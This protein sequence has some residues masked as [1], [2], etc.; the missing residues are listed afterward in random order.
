MAEKV[1]A[2]AKKYGKKCSRVGDLSADFASLDIS[3]PQIISSHAP[4]TTSQRLPLRTRSGNPSRPRRRRQA[5]KAA[6]RVEVDPIRPSVYNRPLLEVTGASEIEPFDQWAET[7][8]QHLIVTKIGD[9][10]YADVYKFAARDKPLTDFV[11]AKLIPILPEKAPL[12]SWGD[13]TTIV[14]AVREIQLLD[15]VTEIP[16]FV[17]FRGAKVL[18]GPLP[19]L[20]KKPTK[21]FNDQ[22]RKEAKSKSAFRRARYTYPENQLWLLVEM[23]DA[24]KDL[25]ILLQGDKADGPLPL[26]MNPHSKEKGLDIRQTRDIFWATANALAHGEHHTQFE[27]RDLH[28]SNICVKR[29]KQ[30]S[31]D[32]TYAF[33]PSSSQLEVVL[34][35][36]TLSRAGT[37]E[38]T[39]Y[40]PMDDEGLFT[41]KGDLQF[42]TYRH[43]RTAVKV[44]RKA[45]WEEFVPL[46]NVLWLHHL[47]VKLLEKTHEPVE[48]D[49]PKRELWQSMKRLRDSTTPNDMTRRWD[50]LSARDIVVMGKVGKAAFVS[51]VMELSGEEALEENEGLVMQK[52]KAERCERLRRE[53]TLPPED[54]PLPRSSSRSF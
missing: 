10:S 18:W 21:Q 27:H 44:N 49:S 36:Y 4:S 5:R 1:R 23:S 41:G 16:G 34:I 30:S 39:I 11:I 51:E 12:L 40:N 26:T 22:R 9:G 53:S 48:D 32:D 14:D 19:E 2:K 37:G 7:V 15:L 17:E 52:A 20:I 50:Y 24:G 38:K 33:I 35:D 46:T 8:Q 43:M 47:L 28:L 29:N 13:M 31:N 42:D 25:D 45:R 54:I 6:P 3:D